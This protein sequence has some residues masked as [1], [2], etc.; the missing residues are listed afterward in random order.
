MKSWDWNRLS[1]QSRNN[2]TRV[3]ARYPI[4]WLINF[5]QSRRRGNF[6]GEKWRNSGQSIC[7]HAKVRSCFMSLLVKRHA[8]DEIG[9]RWGDI[10]DV[11]I[12]CPWRVMRIKIFRETVAFGRALNS[13]VWREE[14]ADSLALV[15]ISKRRDGSIIEQPIVSRRLNYSSVI[16]VIAVISHDLWERSLD[17]SVVTAVYSNEWL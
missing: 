2:K 12:G 17:R 1:E 9:S 10:V 14:A 11:Y 6:P 15:L 16:L 8:E 13:R 5:K 3:P 7:K 4:L